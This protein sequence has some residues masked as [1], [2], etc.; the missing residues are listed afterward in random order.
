MMVGRLAPMKTQEVD[1][2]SNVSEQHPMRGSKTVVS[3]LRRALIAA[4]NR[5]ENAEL[6]IVKIEKVLADLGVV[7]P[8][9][10][11]PLSDSD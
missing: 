9:E 3:T 8:P 7:E 11:K 1:V 6:Q 2:R 10:H 4:R 5:R